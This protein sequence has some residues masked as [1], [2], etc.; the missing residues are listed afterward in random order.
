MYK[1]SG[2]GYCWNTGPI[3]SNHLVQTPTHAS[4]ER[5]DGNDWSI[6]C[7]CSPSRAPLP[8][9]RTVPCGSLNLLERMQAIGRAPG[10]SACMEKEWDMEL[11]L[12]IKEWEDRRERKT[13][14]ES[15]RECVLN[16]CNPNVRHFIREL[17][18][19]GSS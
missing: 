19:F 11:G 3:L 6:R 18:T 14:I 16:G 15:L 12:E 8:S 10:T 2:Q 5:Q 17:M 7:I 13:H 4:L 1:A 9:F